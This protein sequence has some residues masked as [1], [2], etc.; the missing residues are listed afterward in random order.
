MDFVE[1][2]ILGASTSVVWFV[3]RRTVIST[4]HLHELE[5]QTSKFALL[6]NYKV[7]HIGR[8]CPPISVRRSPILA[9]TDRGRGTVLPLQHLATLYLTQLVAHSKL[10][11]TT[12]W[13]HLTLNNV[14]AD[15]K[16]VFLKIFQDIQ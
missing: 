11:G 14:Q 3:N 4:S 16:P 2:G 7:R 1:A 15:R 9:R 5:E 12:L 13:C 6:H 10:L 8:E